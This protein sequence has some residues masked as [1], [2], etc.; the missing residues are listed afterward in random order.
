MTVEHAKGIVMDVLQRCR[1]CPEGLGQ[2]E[3]DLF[4]ERYQ[5]GMYGPTCFLFSSMN[6]VGANGR[7]PIE[8]EICQWEPNLSCGPGSKWH[9][10]AWF[11]VK[12]EYR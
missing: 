4:E 7:A 10:W 11:Q 9:S 1:I 8:V 6:T 5:H 12:A 2:L 3:R